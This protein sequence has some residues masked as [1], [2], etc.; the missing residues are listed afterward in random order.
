LEMARLGTVE[1]VQIA[2]AD[3]AEDLEPRPWG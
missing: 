3:A 2:I 1:R